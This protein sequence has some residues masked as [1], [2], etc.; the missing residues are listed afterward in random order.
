MKRVEVAA[1]LLFDGERV[2][3]CQRAAGGTHPGKWEFPGGKRE[4]GETMRACLAR[5]LFEELGVEATIG[6]ELWRT[7]HS[8]AAGEVELLFFAVAAI[9]R[10]PANLAFGAIHWVTPLELTRLDLLE[11]DRP[12]ADRLLR[13]EIVLPRTAGV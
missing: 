12:L 4:A 13:A 9:D 7:V 5:E 2:L 3:A 11:A 8:Y 1:G 6:A 10:P